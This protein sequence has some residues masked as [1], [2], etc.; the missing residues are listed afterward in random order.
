MEAELTQKTPNSGAEP[1]N[2]KLTL[3]QDNN[4]IF[5]FLAIAQGKETGNFFTAMDKTVEGFSR[6]NDAEKLNRQV[7]LPYRDWETDRKSTRLNSSH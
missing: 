2:I 3:I 1:L 6:L 7:E 4:K 5:R